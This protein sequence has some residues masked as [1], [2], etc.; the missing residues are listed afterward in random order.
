[1]FSCGFPAVWLIQDYSVSSEKLFENPKTIVLKFH[2]VLSLKRCLSLTSRGIFSATMGKISL[3]TFV[4][5]QLRAA[6]QRK[7][8]FR[9]KH[10]T[11]T[12]EKL[13]NFYSMASHKLH[14]TTSFSSKVNLHYVLAHDYESEDCNGCCLRNIKICGWK[15]SPSASRHYAETVVLE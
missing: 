4:V 8:H 1:M 15:S 9:V 7:G 13:L 5:S 10:K 2:C 3:A 6:Q 11:L 14:R 12:I